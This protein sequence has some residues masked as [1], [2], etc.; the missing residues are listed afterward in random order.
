MDEEKSFDENIDE[1]QSALSDVRGL[2]THQ[3]RLAFCLSN[4]IAQLIEDYLKK[5]NALKQ[6]NRIDHQWF[7]R[8]KENVREILADKLTCP[9]EK[10]S[11]VD[12]LLDVAYEIE[13][14]RNDIAYG[15]KSDEKMLSSLINLFLNA[16]KEVENG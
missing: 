7:K 12:Y 11:K 6:G 16:K 5:K 9:V 14:K 15:K 8:K 3:K 1:I 13:S 4:G 2:G 10:L